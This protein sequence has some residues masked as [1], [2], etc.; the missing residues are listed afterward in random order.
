MDDARST[1]VVQGPPGAQAGALPVT[2]RRGLKGAPLFRLPRALTSDHPL[3]WLLPVTATL[4][5]FGLYPLGYAVW[6]SLHQWNRFTR[7]FTFAG[8]TQWTNALSD[9]RTWNAIGVTFTYTAVCLLMQLAL[10]LAI[11]LLLDTDR[12]GYGFFARS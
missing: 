1:L 9:E 5:V 6:L 3:P 7:A 11:A 12:R 8:A 2:L 10:G 4:V